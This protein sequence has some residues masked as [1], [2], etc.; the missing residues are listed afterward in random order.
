[1][2]FTKDPDHIAK[3]Q[4]FELLLCDPP[5]QMQTQMNFILKAITSKVLIITTY[6]NKPKIEGL[7]P[8]LVEYFCY[9]FDTDWDTALNQIV[10]GIKMYVQDSDVSNFTALTKFRHTQIPSKD[11]K[12]ITFLPAKID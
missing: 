3:W 10:K 5:E 7:I 9:Y 6:L 4:E 12:S 1:M 8:E 2:E 11:G